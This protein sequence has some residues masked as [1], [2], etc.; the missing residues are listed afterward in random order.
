MIESI[1]YRNLNGTIICEFS[2]LDLLQKN[3]RA[4]SKMSFDILECQ[5][6]PEKLR[7]K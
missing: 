5:M 6:T 4:F 2:S 7:R 3:G 1:Y